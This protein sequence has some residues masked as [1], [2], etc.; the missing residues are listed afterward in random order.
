M[1]SATR[2]GLLVVIFAALLFGAYSMLGVSLFAKKTSSYFATFADAGGVTSGTRVQMAGVSIGTVSEVKLLGPKQAQFALKIDEDVKIP[3]GSTVQIPTSLIGLGDMTVEVVPSMETAMATPGTTFTGA[4]ASAF[5]GILAGAEVTLGELNKTMAAFRSVLEDKA[6][7]NGMTE[8]L[9]TTSKTLSQFGNLAARL[10]S[11]VAQNQ[12]EI[13]KTI[14]SV[15]RVVDDVQSASKA[16]ARMINEGKIK[17]DTYAILDSIK[18]ISANADKLVAS[19]DKLVNDPKL[20]EPAAAAASNVQK[21]T[22]SGTRIAASAEK[23]AADGT[24]VSKN[25]ITLTEQAK[26]IA[27]HAIEIEK[28]LQT[29]LDKVGGFFNKSSSGPSLNKVTTDFSL[30]HTTKPGHS[31]IDFDARYPT[32]EGFI[33]FGVYDALESNKITLQYGKPV[34][35]KLDYRYGVYASKPGF[36]VDFSL[37]PKV[38]VRGDVWDINSPRFD[39]KARYDIGNGLIGWFGVDRVF[40]KNSPMIGLG[41]KK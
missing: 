17:K 37:A 38:E 16:I 2:V 15:R 24:V 23:I 27:S 9:A 25:A 18:S 5:G 4:K 12:A 32:G 30:L 34:G 29:V 22:E 31:R 39:L 3:V 7:R 33:G 36:G 11:T 6:L 35:S 8:T 21:M 19:L 28:Q 10:D 13:G 1:Q 40:S 20:R 14:V 41:I 26:E